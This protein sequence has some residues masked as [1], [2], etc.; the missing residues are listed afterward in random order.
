MNSS[1]TIFPHVTQIPPKHPLLSN[2]IIP[3]SIKPNVIQPLLTQPTIA[4]ITNNTSLNGST[5]SLTVTNDGEVLA[6]R[7]LQEIVSQVSPNQRADSD[8]EEVS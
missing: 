8:A 7:K 6:R 4:T 3:H 5:S 1:G 2:S